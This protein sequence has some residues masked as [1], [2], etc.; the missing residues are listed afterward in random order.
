MSYESD[1]YLNDL[2]LLIELLDE[3]LDNGFPLAMESN[4]LKGLI[5]PP[6][7]LSKFQTAITGKNTT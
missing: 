7:T 4:V 5:R 2:N 1:R 3:M 6:T